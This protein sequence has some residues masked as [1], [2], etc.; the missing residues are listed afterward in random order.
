M[1]PLTPPD[2]ENSSSSAQIE[3]TIKHTELCV[4]ISKVLRERSGL[5]VTPEQRKAA[6]VNADESLANW[7]LM[8]PSALQRRSSDISLWTSN[9]HLT[10]NNFL[11]LLHR[12]CPQG[13]QK[14]EDYG[15]HDADICSTAANSITTIFEDLRSK[16]RLK[17]LWISSANAL[18]TAMIQVSVELRFSNP[19]LAINARHR[20]LSTLDSLRQLSDYWIIAESIL[21]LFESSPYIQSTIGH[22]ESLND[23][24]T[25]TSTSSYQNPEDTLQSTLGQLQQQE[26]QNGNKRGK[27]S[28]LDV[29]AAAANAAVERINAGVIEQEQEEVTDWRQLFPFTDSSQDLTIPSP[30]VLSMEEE[31]RQLYWQDPGI[32]ASFGDGMGGWS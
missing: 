5:R 26:S 21:R 11:I 29:L 18:F 27:Q 7:C 23:Q 25:S 22:E 16:D 31:W 2:F 1:Q 4:L 19:I 8:L 14:P 30:D 17:Y 10:Y 28:E 32:L 24:V 13:L 9:L 20:F 6:L 15:P 3:Y 12:P